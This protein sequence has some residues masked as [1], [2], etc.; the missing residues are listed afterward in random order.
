[1]PRPQMTG[2]PAGAS[3]APA[4]K[5]ALVLT[6]TVRQSIG[7][8]SVPLGQSPVKARKGA[9]LET[10][11]CRSG[12]SM[13]PIWTIDDRACATPGLSATVV[14]LMHR[15]DGIGKVNSAFIAPFA[16]PPAR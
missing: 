11:L 4:G 7:G 14:G 3:S 8:R 5:A 12:Q 1:M 10:D 6:D 15:A 9:Q 2:A 16:P 13:I